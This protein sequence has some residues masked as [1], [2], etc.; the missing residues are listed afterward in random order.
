MGYTCVSTYAMCMNDGETIRRR[1]RV[2]KYT[3]PGVIK[4][5]GRWRLVHFG[6]ARSAQG[7]STIYIPRQC[8]SKEKSF[9]VYSLADTVI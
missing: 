7:T 4:Y 3:V 6:T 5:K 1:H 2:I 9:G 8:M